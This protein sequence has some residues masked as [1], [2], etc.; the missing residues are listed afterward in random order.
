MKLKDS[1]KCMCRPPAGLSYDERRRY[2]RERFAS[3]GWKVLSCGCC[4]ALLCPGCS[5]SMM[6]S[7]AVLCKRKQQWYRSLIYPDMAGKPNMPLKN[8]SHHC[9]RRY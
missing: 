1:K 6:E 5:M 4:E 3:G 9:R 7:G 2:Y 8:K